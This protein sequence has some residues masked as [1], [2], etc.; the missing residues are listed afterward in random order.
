MESLLLVLALLALFLLLLI[1]VFLCYI[2]YCLKL[3][4]LNAGASYRPA[5][6]HLSPSVQPIQE[7]Q[8]PPIHNHY[9]DGVGVQES[10][11]Q[12]QLP[13]SLIILNKAWNMK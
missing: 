13:V 6:A 8:S 7:T 3:G 5:V 1:A 12:R 10:L 4:M 2:V 11:Y 9:G